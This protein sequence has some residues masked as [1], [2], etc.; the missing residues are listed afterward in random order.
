MIAAPFF[1]EFG[2]E[3]SLWVPWLR[4]QMQR[5]YPHQDLTVL[6]QPGHE[7]LYEDFA[8]QIFKRE[9][10][11][12]VTAIDCQNCWIGG[13]RLH[14]DTYRNMVKTAQGVKQ[15]PK[16]SVFTPYDLQTTWSNEQPPHLGKR[17]SFHCYGKPNDKQ[18]G[19]IAVHARGCPSKQPERNW[20]MAKW[21]KLLEELDAK[22][23]VA[24]GTLDGSLR[25]P[26]AENLR[27]LPLRDVCDAVSR[28]Q[29]IVGP[30]SGPL[31]LAMLCGTPV[32]WWS[33]ND[34][35]EPRFHKLW[36][37]FGVREQQ[38]ARSWD[39]DPDEVEYACQRF[40]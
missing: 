34:K 8:K 25:P 13:Q 32:V 40:L 7:Y 17:G 29:V 39:P 37:P 5:H 12:V 2:W 38:V 10:P 1:G 9:P 26:G 4:W 35:D 28:C 14:E 18:E 30:S 23:V 19:W 15:L 33:P 31:A 16:R 27:G 22:H 24:I 3:V 20:P 21:E 6:C 36:N 11:G